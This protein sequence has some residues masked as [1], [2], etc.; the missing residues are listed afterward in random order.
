MPPP[1]PPRLTVVLLTWNEERNI[2]SCLAALARQ[3]ERS[4]E[5]VVIDAA[6]TDATVAR[7]QEAAKGFPV[8]LRLEVADSKVPIG[9]ARN[10]GVAMARAPFIAF[11]S[12]DAE[13][14]PHWVEEALQTLRSADMA[15]G[16]QV[17]APHK[18]GVGE[19]V[20]G[21]R[22]HFPDRPTSNPLRYASN[23]AGAFRADV[24]RAYPFDPWASAAED[25]LLVRKAQH[26]GYHATYNPAMVVRHH[27]VDSAR[28]ELRKNLR[29]GEGWALYAHDLGLH[30][31]VLAWGAL[32][33]FASLLFALGPGLETL[34]L[35]AG[36]LWA[37]ALRRAARRWDAMPARMVLLGAAASPPFDLAFLF[38][39]ARA[40]LRGR[41]RPEA[42]PREADA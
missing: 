22:Y 11:L 41:A 23:V 31:A 6:S 40:L 9:E 16:K 39:Y 18:A 27:D 1:S 5:V 20:R 17:H 37:P 35:L 7:V 3:R 34:L 21:L 38:S 2:A 4:F 10:R 19:A 13:P 29:E 26:E 24:L 36:V 25:L 28:A 30:A 42:T 33:G 8:P 15:F 12:A 14:D 32:V